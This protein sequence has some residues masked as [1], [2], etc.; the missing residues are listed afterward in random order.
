MMTDALA[1]PQMIVLREKASGRSFMVHIGLFEAMAINRH[2]HGDVMP[3][4]MTHDL[5][6]SIVG[7]LGARITRMTV[8][9]LVEDEDGNGTFFG[10]V[11]LERDGVEIEVDCRP[12]DGIALAVRAGCPV[13]VSRS[14]LDRV[15]RE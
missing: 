4:P 8:S 7:T 14:V 5:L 10:F 2:V 15:A 3:R 12:S 1:S 13:F 11:V 6:F 9:D